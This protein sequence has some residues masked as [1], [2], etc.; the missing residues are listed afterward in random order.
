M[1]IVYHTVHQ[2]M[3]YAE[4]AGGLVWYDGNTAC[5]KYQHMCPEF[6]PR[7]CRDDR[8]PSESSEQNDAMMIIGAVNDNKLNVVGIGRTRTHDAIKHTP[9]AATPGV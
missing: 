2:Q 9:C 4:V 8:P 1:K 7:I 5:I 3:L 6:H